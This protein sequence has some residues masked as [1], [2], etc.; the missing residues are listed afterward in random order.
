MS[1]DTPSN[2]PEA[3]P[4]ATVAP[5]KEL[6][7]VLP[8]EQFVL[9][10]SIIAPIIVGDDRSKRLVDD[11]LNGSRM[12]VV[13]TKR[14]D[15]ESLSRFTSLYDTGSAANILKMLKMPDGTV[16]LL[17]HGMRRVRITEQVGEDPYLLAQVETLTETNPA[18]SETQAMVKSIHGLLDR[19][20]ELSHLPEDLGAAARNL[21]EPGRLCDLVTSN[22]NLPVGEQVSILEL[23]D[24]KERLQR[25]LVI[26][27]REIEVLE[28]GNKIQSRVKNEMD[29]NQR[30]YY[31][32]EQ[33]KAIRRELGDDDGG[34]QT[35]EELQKRLREKAMPDYARQAAEKE[36]ARLSQMQPSSAAGMSKDVKKEA[37]KQLGRLESMHPDSSEATVIRTYLDWMTELPWKKQSKDRLDVKA[38]KEILDE[39][40]FDLEKVK[41]RILEYL[42]VLKLKNDMKGPILCLAGPPGV[43]KTSL[44]R[45]IARA[46]DRRFHR[47][48]LGG[49]RDEA[50]IR[51][52]RR[53]YIG[54]MPGRI[55]KGLKQ[56]GTNNPVIMLDEI[57][58]LGSDYRGDP[59]A[60]LLEVLDPEQNNTFTDNYLDMPFDLSRVL[61]ITTANML[62]TIPGP[63]RDRMEIITLSGYTLAEKV[64]IA[65]KYIIPRQMAENGIA[66]RK[67]AFT[68]EAVEEIVAGYTRE[69][70]LRNLERE[71][72]SVCRKIAH[73]VALGRGARAPR[74][75]TRESVPGFLGRQRYQGETAQRMGQ[76]GVAI[77][78]AWTPVGG[79]ILFIE[80]SRTRGAGNLTLTGQLGDVMK[81]SARAAMTFLHE[82]ASRLHISEEHFAKHDVHLHVPAGATPKDGPS[83]GITMCA[84][85]ASL[86]TGRRLK[87][88]L[89]MT[90]EITLKGNVLPVGGIKEK[91]L[92]A[93]RAGIREV[94][95]PARNQADLDQLP[96]DIRKTIRFHPVENA[97]QV[98]ELAFAPKRTRKPA[99]PVRK[100]RP[101]AAKKAPPKTG[102]KPVP[103]TKTRAGRR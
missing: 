49:M 56:A 15:A 39:D 21:A 68:D 53:T 90:G 55:L 30:D 76:A 73:Q 89:A 97:A 31:L 3:P 29:K 27:N 47:L 28:L 46:L 32:R 61:F 96:D 72:G 82:H 94:I 66:A 40:H 57:D 83:A 35:N 88:F 103:K 13:V 87:D 14:P 65:R 85:L 63:L 2:P 52:H 59:S 93:A 10:P 34:A 18:D 102:K 92:A 79:D 5:P 78:L 24:V 12:V 100:V 48:S 6:L 17:V 11:A 42:S 45:S 36:L 101:A 43:G 54:S 60:A 67:V 1:D 69:A 86:F 70:G 95:L 33:M 51:G 20:V 16:R 84:A 81:E 58:K 99:G 7:P 74:K 9:F 50:E 26:L 98:L 75:V 19:A 80:C 91:V 23:A 25:L 64:M 38:A 41:E 8:V 37:L 44:G 71:I 22:L 77:G 4:S 62:E